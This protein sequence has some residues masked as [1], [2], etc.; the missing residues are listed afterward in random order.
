ME[1]HKTIANT[2]ANMASK[3]WSMVSIYIFVP[4]YIKY[5]GEEAYGL[6][7]F[8]TTMQMALNLLGLGLSS[9]LRREF[10]LNINGG[11]EVNLRKYK[12]LRSIE[13]FFSVIAIVIAV[14]CCGSAR[15]IAEK[16]LDSS[17]LGIR[18]VATTVGLM[19]ISI[20][21]QLLSQLYFGA[22]L[23]L[24]RQVLANGLNVLYA[25]L[26]AVGS[27]LVIVFFYADIR[28]FYV[29]HIV[30]DI[31]YIFVLRIILIRSIS[32]TGALKWKPEDFWIIRDIWKYAI[33]LVTIS[34]VAF[35]N[36]QLDRIVISKFM[37]L[38]ELGAYNSCYTLGQIVTIISSAVA[39]AIFSEFAD[40]YSKNGT[41]KGLQSLYV[42]SYKIVVIIASSIG[43]FVAV[44]SKALLLFWTQSK[45]YV[46]IMERGA[47]L[48]VIGTMILAFQEIPYAFVLAQGNTSIN[49][50]M[51]LYF[52]MPFIISMYI[53]VKR[54]GVMGAATVYFLYMVIQTF[55]YVYIIFKKYCVG[56]AFKWIIKDTL[57]PTGVAVLFAIGSQNFA[58]LIGLDGV[59]EIVFAVMTG[60]IALC[61]LIFIFDREIILK[62]IVR[63]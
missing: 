44:Y 14:A 54:Y 22:M 45:S 60:G 55:L 61:I 62:R 33:G 16:W 8:F 50:K 39:T 26:K 9:T 18:V 20:A 52:L 7:S 19:G 49:R 43:A 58:C 51:G 35:V 38:T 36:K 10:A 47:G 32:G 3:L 25:A 1:K 41:K 23:G 48:I 17:V 13:A 59:I 4:L 53:G 5:L 21:L 37:T 42:S 24:A 56:N 34:M 11:Y 12:L 57:L 40:E 30:T 46:S 29:W 27:V 6:I 28:A 31:V 63:R 15:L 2:I